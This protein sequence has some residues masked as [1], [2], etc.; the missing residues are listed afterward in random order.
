MKVVAGVG[1]DVKEGDTL[2]LLEAMKMETAVSSPRDGK[3]VK[4]NV[5]AGDAVSVGDALVELA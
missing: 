5:S 4:V 2:L 1:T 3:V